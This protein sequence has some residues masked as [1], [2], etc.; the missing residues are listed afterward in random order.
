[1]REEDNQDIEEN[2]R[3]I[4]LESENKRNTMNLKE[5]SQ[6]ELFVNDVEVDECRHNEQI[7]TSWHIA[8]IHIES[9]EVL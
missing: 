6:K 3:D 2:E 8:R 7:D 9:N 4:S 5:E 1:M